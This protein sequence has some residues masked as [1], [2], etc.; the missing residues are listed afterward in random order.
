MPAFKEKLLKKILSGEKTQTRRVVKPGQKLIT[1]DGLKTVIEPS[2]KIKYQVGRTYACTYGRGKGTAYYDVSQGK[3]TL[4]TW[5]EV[6]VSKTYDDF[7]QH[8]QPLHYL[9]LDIREETDVRRISAED[10][11]AEGF[12]SKEEFL[13]TWNLLHGTTGQ[14]GDVIID[15]SNLRPD[16]YH[17]F[18]YTF[19]LVQSG[20]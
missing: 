4:L 16:P 5:D 13:K 18:A 6:C 19:K 8:Y 7:E 2:G 17:A 1:R 12:K 14:I 9:L 15:I 10:A 20:P 11:I 3:A